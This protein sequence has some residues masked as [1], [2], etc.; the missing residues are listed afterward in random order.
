MNQD[1][2]NEKIEACQK[3]LTDFNLQLEILSQK[4]DISDDDS[5]AQFDHII[6]QIESITSELDSLIDIL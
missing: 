4:D 3:R 2:I 6:K 1:E 5:Q